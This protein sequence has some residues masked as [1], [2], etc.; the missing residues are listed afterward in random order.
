MLADIFI[1]GIQ[2]DMT[3]TEYQPTGF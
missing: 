1:F 3:S 2:F